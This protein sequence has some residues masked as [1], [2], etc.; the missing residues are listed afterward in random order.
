MTNG[1]AT[2]VRC[3]L[4]VLA[5]SELDV[6]NGGKIVIVDCLGTPPPLKPTGFTHFGEP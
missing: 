2:K 4:R 6:V 3:E 5:D 1:P